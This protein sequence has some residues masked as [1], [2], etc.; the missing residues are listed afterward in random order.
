MELRLI[1]LWSWLCYHF[2]MVWPPL[3]QPA[4]AMLPWAGLY[5]H[6]ADFEAFRQWWPNRHKVEG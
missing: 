4:W 2:V 3:W 5:A 1:W 6:T